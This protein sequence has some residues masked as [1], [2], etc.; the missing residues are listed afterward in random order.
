M[1]AAGVD[2]NSIF[3]RSM[4][5]EA[6]A[7]TIA[8][9]SIGPVLLAISTSIFNLIASQPD[10]DWDL[11]SAD[12]NTM[13]QQT[14]FADVCSV[15]HLLPWDKIDLYACNDLGENIMHSCCKY[16]SDSDEQ[17]RIVTLVKLLLRLGAQ[18]LVLG[19]ND[20]GKR[21]SEVGGWPV[22]LTLLG[23]AEVEASHIVSACLSR[24]IAVDA[25]TGIIMSYYT[26]FS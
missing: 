3:T 8:T 6:L 14:L 13:L 24:V 20:D 22:L 4:L 5:T 9:R 10:V 1:I 17:D 23:Q 15:Q 16:D 26:T 2:V 12:G 25:L 19:V 11:R 21:P 18:G 7:V